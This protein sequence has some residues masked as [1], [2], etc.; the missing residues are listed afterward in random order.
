MRRSKSTM[1]YGTDDITTI[2][3]A[4]SVRSRFIGRAQARSIESEHAAYLRIEATRAARRFP[5]ILDKL[6][7]GAL[8]VT[9]VSLLGPHLT[10]ANHVELLDMARHKSKRGTKLAATDRPHTEAAIATRHS[11]HIPSAVTRNVWTRDGG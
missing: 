1:V 6:S 8:H 2:V 3:R 4:R 9:A 11:R 5:V 7:E 10:A